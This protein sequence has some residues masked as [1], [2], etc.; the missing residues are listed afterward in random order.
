MCV[1]GNV[2]Y[3]TSPPTTKKVGERQRECVSPPKLL[4]LYDMNF[5]VFFVQLSGPSTKEEGEREEWGVH[6]GL[7]MFP[8]RLSGGDKFVHI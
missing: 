1:C 5:L 8:L 3:K 4:L 6:W 2:G 7:S